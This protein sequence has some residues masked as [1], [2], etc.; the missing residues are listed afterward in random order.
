MS[1]RCVAI[2]SQTVRRASAE[3]H[4]WGRLV[5]VDDGVIT[6]AYLDGVG[7]YR[8]HRVETLANIAATGSKVAVRE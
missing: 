3:R 8:N 5:A 6:V 4:D 1:D 7:R 2:V